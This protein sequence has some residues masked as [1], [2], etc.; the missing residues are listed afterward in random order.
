QE[1]CSLSYHSWDTWIQVANLAVWDGLPEDVREVIS[2]NMNEAGLAQRAD[3]QSLA[4][5]LQA[6][7]EAKGMKFVTPDRDAFREA[8]KAA[9]FY[10]EWRKAYGEEAWPALEIAVGA[11]G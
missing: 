3:I 5:T 9:G 11:L 4:T 7:L 1:Y 10:A 2:R 6:D 8:L